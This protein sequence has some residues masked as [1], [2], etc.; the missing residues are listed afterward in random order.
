M[1]IVIFL[2]T[3]LIPIAANA[4]PQSN[5]R[6]NGKS[7]D[8]S[9]VVTTKLEN[10]LSATYLESLD[11]FSELTGD[12][13]QP[14]FAIFSDEWKPSIKITANTLTLIARPVLKLEHQRSRPS[15]GQLVV[16]NKSSAKWSEL[17]ASLQAT[18]SM[19]FAAG[20]H[21]FQWGSGELFNAS[22]PIFGVDLN[23]KSLSKSSLSEP[24]SRNLARVNLS[25]GQNISF[26]VMAAYQQESDT[27]TSPNNSVA[28]ENTEKES[29][30]IA[31]KGEFSGDNSGDYLGAVLGGRE[32]GNKPFIGA[33]GGTTFS[34]STLIY[35]D[36]GWA[37][38][39]QGVYPSEPLPQAINTAASN[40]T[41]SGTASASSDSTAGIHKSSL[42]PD[43]DYLALAELGARYTFVSGSDIK[44][45]LIHN[46][47]GYDKNQMAIADRLTSASPVLLLR[48]YRDSQIPFLWQNAALL[49]FH[50]PELGI[51]PNLSLTTRYLKPF[52]DNSGAIFIFSEYDIND[53]STA[54]V[55]ASRF[56]GPDFSR[57]GDIYRST[58]NIG[59][60][61]IW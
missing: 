3:A 23:G 6:A 4:N 35:F 52:E 15:K 26:V 28:S 46:Q 43:D 8:N 30:P 40:G 19:S 32:S 41:P 38:Y 10:Y 2:L 54:F 31:V 1:L 27:E 59:C 16:N 5:S 48:Y 47:A 12:N 18:P 53:N 36:A 22:N 44:F 58:A 56:H 13:V 7:H 33:Y 29:L 21:N 24:N 55:A 61:L 20:R 42:E 14:P 57:S 45:E 9:I 25:W 11:N 51:G 39:H 37:P 50:F 17:Y 34:D 60:R 49:A